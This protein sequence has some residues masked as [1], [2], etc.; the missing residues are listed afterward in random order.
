MPRELEISGVFIPP[1]LPVLALSLICA[2]LTAYF[3]NKYRLARYF[4]VPQLV[5][6]GFVAIYGVLFSTFLIRV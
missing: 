1:I 2:W 5:F 3:L 6:L 4:M